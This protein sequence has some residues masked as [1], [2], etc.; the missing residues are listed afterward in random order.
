MSKFSLYLLESR[1]KYTFKSLVNL[2]DGSVCVRER[3]E[4]T[5]KK[6]FIVEKTA[7]Q[8]IH[9]QPLR[10]KNYCYYFLTLMDDDFAL[11]S[12]HVYIS[13][14]ICVHFKACEW[15]TKKGKM[16]INRQNSMGWNWTQT[17]LMSTVELF[18]SPFN[19][20]LLFLHIFN[21]IYQKSAVKL[22]HDRH[23]PKMN[24]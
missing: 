24:K 8:I 23:H 6:R 11:T 1:W 9:R 15:T 2:L 4:R 21:G 5:E 14:S 10:F 16:K 18:V 19:S 3:E 12:T 20:L 7:T 22:A 13:M 17:N